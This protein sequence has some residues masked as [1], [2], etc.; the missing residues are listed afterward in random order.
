MTA[1]WI[2]SQFPRQI[3]SDLSRFHKRRIADWLR[4]TRDANGHLAFDSYELLVYLEYMDDEGEFKKAAERRG[5]WSI[6]Q[7][8]KAETFNETARL[9]ASIH[10]AF[11]G[12]DAVFKPF[13]FVDPTVAVERERRAAEEQAAQRET[14]EDFYAEIGFS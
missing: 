13:E 6:R 9:R 1:L 7:L 4:G 14:E 11:G 10:A 2:W 8:I 12:K 5:G 3:A